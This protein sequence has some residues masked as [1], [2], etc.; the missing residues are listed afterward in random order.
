[1]TLT[2]VTRSYDVIH[3]VT[4]SSTSKI[5]IFDGWWFSTSDCV[6]L[7]LKSHNLMSKIITLIT[8]KIT[9]SNVENHHP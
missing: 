5:M 9:Q 7:P 8:L 4:S 2:N 6:I 1:M 3:V